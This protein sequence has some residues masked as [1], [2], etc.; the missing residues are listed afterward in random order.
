[1]REKNLISGYGISRGS[2]TSAS[3]RLQLQTNHFLPHL[4]L[5]CAGDRSS[6]PRSRSRPSAGWGTANRPAPTARVSAQ[7][8]FGGAGGIAQHP[9]LLAAWSTAPAAWCFP[10]KP[11]RLRQLSPAHPRSRGWRRPWMLATGHP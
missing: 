4:S 1:M 6:V 11:E 7:G 8:L 3:V 9:P 2:R 10:G 5:L